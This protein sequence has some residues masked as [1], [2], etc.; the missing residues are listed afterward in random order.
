MATVIGL[1]IFLAIYFA[2]TALALLRHHRSW[3]AVLVINFFFGWTVIGWIA[4][5]AKAAGNPG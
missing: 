3:G 1:L 5:L 4:A 2:P